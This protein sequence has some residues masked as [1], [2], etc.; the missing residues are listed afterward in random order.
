[1]LEFFLL[2]VSIM[3]LVKLFKHFVNILNLLSDVHLQVL[4]SSS[5]VSFLSNFGSGLRRFLRTS[6][7]DLDWHGIELLLK[8]A[9]GLFTIPAFFDDKDNSLVSVGDSGGLTVGSLNFKAQ[10]LEGLSV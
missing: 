2:N 4:S 10:F 5:V 1:M 9:D 7:V 8:L 3:V 6:H